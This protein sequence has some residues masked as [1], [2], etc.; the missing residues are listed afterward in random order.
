MHAERRVETKQASSVCPHPAY[1]QLLAREKISIAPITLVLAS[2]QPVP[3]LVPELALVLV[4]ALVL[5]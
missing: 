2:R 4:S 5:V 1:I 3:A